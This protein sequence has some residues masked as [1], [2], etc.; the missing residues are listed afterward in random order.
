M[1]TFY[2][3]FYKEYIFIKNR[4]LVLIA[5][6]KNSTFIVHP[7][8]NMYMGCQLIFHVILDVHANRRVKL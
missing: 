8:C 6:I 3:E 1:I 5:I 4:K 2:I 7:E